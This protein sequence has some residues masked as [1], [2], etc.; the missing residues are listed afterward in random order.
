MELALEVGDGIHVLRIDM[1]IEYIGGVLGQVVELPPHRRVD[2]AVLPSRG[3]RRVRRFRLPAARRHPPSDGRTGRK[4]PVASQAWEA[5]S[6]RP[7]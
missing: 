1:E 3:P 2:V 4:E 5:G 7:G 6:A